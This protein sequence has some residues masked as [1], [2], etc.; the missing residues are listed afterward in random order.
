VIPSCSKAL[1]ISILGHK[2]LHRI[3]NLQGHFFTTYTERNYPK[4][5][6]SMEKGVTFLCRILNVGAYFYVEK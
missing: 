6:N 4:A 2:N 5:I 3:I 1:D